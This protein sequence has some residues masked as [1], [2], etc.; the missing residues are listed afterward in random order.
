MLKNYIKTT[1]RGLAKNKVYSFLNI[2]G[3][4]IGIAC[5]SLIFL[6]VQDEVTFNHNFAKRDNLYRVMENRITNGV[7][8]TSA[9]A[10]SPLGN[11]MKAEIPGIQNTMRKSWNMSELF[12]LGEKSINEDGAY[13][14]P[15][16]FSMLQ[17]PFVYGNPNGAFKET[18]SVVISQT[19]AKKFF[20]DADPTGKTFRLNAKQNFSVDGVFTVTGVFKDLPA[21]S[22]FQFQW[23]CSFAIWENQN[24]W[25]KG[26]WGNNIVETYAEVQPKANISVIDQKLKNYLATKDKEINTQLFLFPMNDWNLHNN[27][28]NGQQDGG[29]IR[30]VQLFSTIAWIILLIACINFMNLSTA[31][32]EQRA[33]EVGVRK[34]MGAGKG[35]LILQ[36]IGESLMMSFLSVLV[37]VGLLY[38]LLPAFN[39]LVEKQLVINLL[40]PAHLAFI[41]GIGIITG[42]V[43]GSYPAF[44]L[45]SF[46]PVFVLKGIRVKTGA[47][48]NFIRK[49]LVV[50]Q[51]VISIILIISTII[52]YQQVNH[53][54]TRNLGYNKNNLLNINLQGKLKEN[55]EAV[56]NDLLATGMVENAAMNEFLAMQVY[57]SA[58]DFNWAGKNPNNK[59]VINDT[60]VSPGY[61]NTMGIQLLSGRD[62]YTTPKV[63]SNSIVINQ[64][65]AR[66]MGKAGQIGSII[67]IGKYSLTVIGIV[68]DMVYNNM[69]GESDPL[70]IFC[71]PRA[72]NN[73]TIHIKQGADLAQAMAKIG[74]VIK[75]DNPGYPFE[76]SFIDQE[77]DKLFKTESLI[78]KLSSVFALLAIAISCLGLFGLA[79]YTAGRR[80]KEIG[81]R[82][83][84]GASISGLVALLS[85]DFLKLVALSC[86]I[87][88]P[89]AWWA[90]SK[91]LQDY[92]YRI[93]IHWWVFALSG[94]LAML[95]ALVTVSF[96]AIKASLINPAQSLRSE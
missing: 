76:Y 23:L 42:L 25:L 17:L 12:V 35:R 55:F 44:Y 31:R 37:A 63:D 27:F 32:S 2:A 6:W 80:I 69:Y 70:I 16:V 82:K 3:L 89:T 61:I 62:F 54:K 57:G 29:K 26:Q 92:Q 18:N 30:Y 13:A 38:L 73:L 40:N 77:F 96:Q 33:K 46:N 65:L 88:F 66:K 41:I 75:K 85:A 51:F 1:L 43:A 28:T 15:S 87:A 90:M 79:A 5:A 49:G 47:S 52:I 19:L 56:K 8:S 24:S 21:N 67:T 60:H 74:A 20:G 45:S 95:I 7:I 22:T 64:S 4:A 11:A 48:A 91:W 84:L 36:F 71:N 83:V 34:V 78:G 9:S 50:S 39:T 93:S 58:S 72:T 81:V 59:V 94:V 86:L 10:P 53:I 14:D 68:H